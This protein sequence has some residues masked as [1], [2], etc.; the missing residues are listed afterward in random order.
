MIPMTLHR[1]RRRSSAAPCVHDPAR[2]VTGPAVRRQPDRRAGRPLRRRAPASASTATTT[3][4]A[5][6]DAGAAAVLV[7]R[8]T[9]QPGVLVEDPVAALARLARH[10]LSRLTGT[11]GGRADRVAGQ[12][13]HQGPA[14]AGARHGGPHGRHLRLVQQRARAAADRAARRPGHGVPRARDG[15][16]HIGRPPGLV[17]GGAAGRRRWC[18]TSARRTSGEFGSQQAIAQAKGEI[19]E[20][21]PRGRCRGAQRRRPAGRRDGRPDPRAGCAPSA[22]T[23]APTSAS[24]SSRSTTSAARPSCCCTRAERA[25]GRDAAWSASTTPATPRPPQRSRSRSGCGLDDGGRRARRRHR[26]LP[27]PDGGARAGR[28]RDRR[29]RRLQRQP[30]LH[31]RRAQGARVDRPRPARRPHRSRCS[32]R[33]A[34]WASRRRTST[35]PLAGWPCAWTSTSCSSSAS[36]RGRSTS[37]PPWRGPGAT[38]RSSSRTPTPPREWLHRNLVPGDVVLFKASNAVQLSRVAHAVLAD[39]ATAQTTLPGTPRQGGEQSMRAIL[40]AGGLSLIFT[41]LGTRVAIRVLVTKGYGQLIRDDGP[42]THHTKRGTPTMGGL[43]IIVVGGA[44][45]LRRQADHPATCRR[46]SG[47]AAAVPAGRPRARS[48]SSTTTSRSPS[49]AA[50][51]CAARRRWPGRRWSR[52][53]FGVLALTR[54]PT[55]AARPPRRCT[56]R[57]SATSTA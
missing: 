37:E 22:P 44:R 7:H 25:H 32:A 46:W 18:S 24:T 54:S 14:R 11:P 33:C 56:C 9:G 1:D 57:S 48:A 40:L 53:V 3:P 51:A 29:R 26:D 4:T 41:L 39:G 55:S 2:R 21:L 19:V 15:R 17:R 36:R 50:S 8:D 47:P 45:L 16:P 38:S 6:I 42:T 34:S 23:P 49:S 28:R 12:D 13:Q 43:V 27:G 10:A 20:A 31:A 35:T 5:A 52:C 30:G